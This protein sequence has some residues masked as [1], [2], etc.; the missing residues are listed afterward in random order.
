MSLHRYLR[1]SDMVVR[2]GGEEFVLVLTGTDADGARLILQRLLRDWLGMRPD[3]TPLTASI[4]LA[5]RITDDIHDWPQ[6]LEMAD[7][8]MYLAK[9]QGRARAVM[10]GDEVMLSP[11]AEAPRI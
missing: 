6:L 11:A 7:R 1:R 9:R 5:A 8:R 10:C 3:H 4:G 2:W